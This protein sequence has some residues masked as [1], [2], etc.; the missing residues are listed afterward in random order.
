MDKS[1]IFLDA[2]NPD[3][4][5]YQLS[6]E[7]RR[8]SQFAEAMHQLLLTAALM[9]EDYC[10]IP[11]GFVLEDGFNCN[12]IRK[13]GS[14]LAAANVIRFPTRDEGL[15]DLL[16]KKR[17]EYFAERDEYE[18]LYSKDTERGIRV[19]EPAVLSRDTPVGKFI[20]DGISEFG[21]ICPPHVESRLGG[22]TTLER[23]FLLQYPNRLRSDGRAVT[24]PAIANAM[25][26]KHLKAIV[27]IVE[28][29]YGLAY[30]QEY[31]AFVMEGVPYFPSHYG[32]ET[33]IALRRYPVILDALSRCSITPQH[34]LALG[35]EGVLLLRHS[36]GFALFR[37]FLCK[38]ATDQASTKQITETLGVKLTTARKRIKAETLRRPIP[39][40]AKGIDEFVRNID[41]LLEEV[42]CNE[43]D[44]P[45][46]GTLIM[47]VDL[48]AQAGATVVFQEKGAPVHV[49]N[50][51]RQATVNYSQIGQELQYLLNQINDGTLSISSD[52]KRALESAKVATTTKND[53]ALTSGLKTAGKWVLDTA[54]A[55]VTPVLTEYIKTHIGLPPGG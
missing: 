38:L 28:H 41:L 39:T 9:S 10:I 6:T 35:Q 45:E 2:L 52:E 42:F 33:S 37:H 15:G 25:V 50:D 43:A 7:A 21:I 36:V 30:V 46:G 3:Y 26:T 4:Y 51:N 22:F 48:T 55:A 49:N 31:D 47:K 14:K 13:Y 8:S 11:P 53:T 12:L 34:L 40:G 20:A 23:D 54:K 32:L 27:H 16:E 18:Y 5:R 29:L 24:P 19:M 1:R 17:S 44:L